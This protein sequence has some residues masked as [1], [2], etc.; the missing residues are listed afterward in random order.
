MSGEAGKG[1]KPV[2]FN[3]ND[4]RR[5]YEGICWGDGRSKD[6]EEQLKGLTGRVY[7]EIRGNH[8]GKIGYL[9]KNPKPWK[10]VASQD[11]G[12]LRI[13]EH[14]HK[15]EDKYT[16]YILVRVGTGPAIDSFALRL[17]GKECKEL[18]ILPSLACDHGEFV[19]RLDFVVSGHRGAIGFIYC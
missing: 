9:E 3:A 11:A 5:G 10:I 18:I 14:N 16:K 1:D 8:W 19:H 15:H 2:P 6:G 13:Y 17:K 4:Y 12:L 7:Y